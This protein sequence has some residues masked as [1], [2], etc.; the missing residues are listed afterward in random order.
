MPLSISYIC[1]PVWCVKYFLFQTVQSWNLFFCMHRSLVQYISHTILSFTT[2]VCSLLVSCCHCLGPLIEI[3]AAPHLPVTYMQDYSDALCVSSR[4]I[5]LLNLFKYVPL[6]LP[7][8]FIHAA[9]IHAPRSSYHSPV[10]DSS[11]STACWSR[12]PLLPP[13]A[14]TTFS[15]WTPWGHLSC[16]CGSGPVDYKI[17]LYSLRT[18]EDFTF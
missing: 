9:F 6:S 15:V 18:W 4:I 3:S 2:H 5:L 10:A 12:S 7:F 13:T 16:C 11:A 1:K 14:S 17:L 8:I